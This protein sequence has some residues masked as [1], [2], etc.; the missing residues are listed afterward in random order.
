MP[1]SFHSIY[2]HGFVRVAVA[3]P[4]LRVA[5]PSYNLERTIGLAHRASS[6]GAALALS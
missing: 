3:T 2:A 1:R 4:F 6:E 5:D